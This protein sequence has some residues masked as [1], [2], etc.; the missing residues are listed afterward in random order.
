MNRYLTRQELYELV[1]SEPISVIAKRV[2]LSDVGFAKACRRN[3]VPIPERG[4]W[5]KRKAGKPVVQPMLPP[6]GL[7]MH[8][9]TDVLAGSSIGLGI[10]TAVADD[11]PASPNFAEDIEHVETR[12][13]EMVGKV[14][15]PKTF[16]KTHPLITQLLEEDER[17]RQTQKASAY[18]YSWDKPLF[19]APIERRR[20]R[21]LNATALALVRCDTKPSMSGREA[22]EFQVQ[23][24][25]QQVS[26]V[27]ER[28]PTR[29]RPIRDNAKEKRTPERLRLR[30]LPW[31]R[32]SSA[33]KS[34]EDRD[35]SPLESQLADVVTSL[36]VAGEVK[37]RDLMQHQYKWLIERKRQEEEEAHRAREEAARR[38]RERILKEQQARVDRLL[39]EAAALRQATDI[40]AYVETVL[41]KAPH[42]HEPEKLDRLR[43]W[44]SW[45]LA[46]ADRIDPIKSERFLQQLGPPTNNS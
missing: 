38:E 28:V 43:A 32:D 42:Q 37:Y 23:V 1:W 15:V 24:G 9:G 41:A 19:D 33:S 11:I 6:R 3:G 39:G 10:E 8:D 29:A 5:A 36:I 35:G 25:Q 20:L 34:W 26:Y 12:V 2:A 18:A 45:A 7:G 13:R 44:A 4:Y 46:E 16:A 17:R 22:K 21:I 14:S 27:L 30:L 40:R 31:G